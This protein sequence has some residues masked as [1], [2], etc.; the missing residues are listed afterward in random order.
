[1][2][3]G[4]DNFGNVLIGP[5]D[6]RYTPNGRATT[7]TTHKTGNADGRILCRILQLG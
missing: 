6:H 1:L 5:I 2:H 3:A 4:L 7:D